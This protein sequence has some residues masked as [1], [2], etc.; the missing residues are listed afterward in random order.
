MI[1]IITDGTCDMN[2]EK[3]NKL[4]IDIMPLT[5]HFGKEDYIQ[6]ETMS[7]KQFYEKLATTKELPRTSQVN[8]FE[9]EKVFRRYVEAGDDVIG[10]FISHFLSG[11]FQ[12]ATIAKDAIGSDR[13]HVVDSMTTTIAMSL[14][15]EKAVQMRDA[16]ATATDVIAEIKRLI[17]LSRFFAAADTL[18][19]LKMG[20]RISSASAFVGSLLG[21]NPIVSVTDGKVVPAGKARGKKACFQFFLAQYLEAHDDDAPT[22][23]AHAN[24]PQRMTECIEYFSDHIVRPELIVQDEMGPIVGTHIGPGSIGF[25]YFVSDGK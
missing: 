18:D 19:Y 11:T 5:I 7:T 20:G 13:I 21:I 16:G 23:F 15:V 4:G 3:A 2:V 8:P 25:T 14:L 6:N 1:R 24:A 22:A 10:I 12:S 9:F 17:P